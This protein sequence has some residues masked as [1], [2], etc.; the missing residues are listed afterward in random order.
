M[1]KVI[2]LRYA[3]DMYITQIYFLQ[4]GDKNLQRGSF[5]A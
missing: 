3:C 5:A 4:L 2:S 1:D